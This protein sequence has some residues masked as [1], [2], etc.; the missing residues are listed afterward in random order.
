MA[1]R[2]MF[3]QRITG[4]SRFLRMPISSQALYFHLGI[5]AD[6]DGVVEAYN[7][8]RYTG[9]AEDDL[10]VLVAKG[11]V[12]I[13]N[14][15]LV[16]YIV[17]WREH[18]LIRADRKVNSIYK[19][20]LLQILPEIEVLAPRER[21]D[22]AKNK[23]IKKLESGRPVDGQW[24]AQD[25]L[26]KDRLI[27]DMK[28]DAEKKEFYP[29]AVKE[30][31]PSDLEETQLLSIANAIGEENMN[32]LLSTK[33]AGNYWAI[34]SAWENFADVDKSKIDNPASYFNSLVQGRIK[35]KK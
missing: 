27:I 24:S 6:D 10:K 29:I 1:I 3:S 22:V 19:D 26:G 20:L 32:F 16:S 35:E 11:F 8:L 28:N 21:V 33:S 15:D 12:K 7:I 14:E 31:K 18:N 2:R 5:N 13:L 25:R 9:I 23:L 4:S 34:Q 30:F 17:D